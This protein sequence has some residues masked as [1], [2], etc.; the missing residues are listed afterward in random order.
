[1]I[2]S[3]SINSIC[4]K[5]LYT[6]LEIVVLIY[7]AYIHLREIAP[8]QNVGKIIPIVCAQFVP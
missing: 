3:I 6:K 8:Q 2:L 4:L 7:H 1:M 5:K